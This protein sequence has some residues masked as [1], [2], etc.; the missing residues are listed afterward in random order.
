VKGVIINYESEGGEMSWGE[1]SCKHKP[2]IIPEECN[3]GTCNVD[4]RGYV[5]DGTTPPDTHTDY[6]G[7]TNLFEQ[8][9]EYNRNRSKK[10]RQ[11]AKKQRS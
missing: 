9:R 6:I 5:W 3:M 10:L 7:R 11:K 2:C 4:C 8:G 1:R